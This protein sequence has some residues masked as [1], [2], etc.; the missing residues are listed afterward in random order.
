MFKKARR[1]AVATINEKAANLPQTGSIFVEKPISV[2]HL[3]NS[4]GCD[5]DQLL[6]MN[7]IDQPLFVRGAINYPIGANR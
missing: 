1:L 7:I 5:P 3:A 2:L 4:L 6:A